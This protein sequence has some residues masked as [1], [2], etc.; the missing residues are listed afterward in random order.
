MTV[1]DW[2][3]EYRDE[4][5]DMAERVAEAFKDLQ[6]VGL[7]ELDAEALVLIGDLRARLGIVRDQVKH[8]TADPR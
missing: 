8:L 2:L 1:V 5:G 4:L 6:Q 7:D 3:V